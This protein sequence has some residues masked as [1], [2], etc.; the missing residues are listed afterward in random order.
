[1]SKIAKIKSHIY[2]SE[3]GTKN[4]FGQPKKV[5]SGVILEIIS[6]SKHCGY[7]ES[8]LSGYL[9]EISKSTLE[10]FSDM[11]IGKKIDDLDKL[12]L[13]IKIPFCSNNGFIK[14]ITSAI[15]IALYD[16]KSRI[17]KKPLYEFLN[18]NYRNSVLGYASGGSVIYSKKEI[19]N[20]VKIAKEKFN[21]YKMRVGYQ[22]LNSDLSRIQEAVKI[23][24]ANKV[25]ID[26]IMGTL[27]KWSYKDFIKI[28]PKFNKMNLKWIEEPI[29]PSNFIDYSLLKKKSKN[30]IA[31]GEAYTSFQEFR[32]IIENN[33]CDIIQPDITQ[34]GI[35]D[36]IRICKYGK[37]KNKEIALHVWGSPLS[38][39]IN[40][41]FALA[42]KE[43][44]FI[45][46]PLVR[47]KIFKEILDNDIQIDSG[48]VR[49]NSKKNGIGFTLNKNYLKKFKFIE[50]SGFSI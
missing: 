46:Y 47:L 48:R 10:Y 42:F 24:G 18:K 30:K 23:M 25:M 27:N 6:E 31:I 39:I 3:Y 45:E 14:S 35:L 13:Q 8:Y 50:K 34:C 17:E 11:L 4:V 26:A 44:D 9:P 21:F 41:H 28:L 43:V 1:V 5:R 40:L 37:R 7:G 2:S 16:L 32:T 38:F 49:L 12:I 29:H 33:C 15:E 22:N 36:A 20:D 19:I